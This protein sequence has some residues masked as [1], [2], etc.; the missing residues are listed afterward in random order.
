M[1]NNLTLVTKSGD[2]SFQNV[3]G[4]LVTKPGDI[5]GDMSPNYVTKPKPHYAEKQQ[6][7]QVTE[8]EKFRANN[9]VKEARATCCA[10]DKISPPP[11]VERGGYFWH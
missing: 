2:I 10:G 7:P 5:S 9:Y 8:L 1:N 3:T 11:F 6:L 4:N